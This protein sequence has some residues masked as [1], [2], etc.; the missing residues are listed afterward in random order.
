MPSFF[1]DIKIRALEGTG[2]SKILYFHLKHK[3]R[4]IESLGGEK[5]Q[6]SIE[7]FLQLY[8]LWIRLPAINRKPD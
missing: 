4:Q 1:L 6:I 8:Q 3:F 2:N 5:T 7:F